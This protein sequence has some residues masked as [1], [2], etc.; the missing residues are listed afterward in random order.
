MTAA[1]CGGIRTPRPLCRPYVLRCTGRVRACARMIERAQQLGACACVVARVGG[2]VQSM[3]ADMERKARDEE[4]KARRR[5]ADSRR[6]MVYTAGRPNTPEPVAGR[7]HAEIQTETF[8][9]V[10]SDRPP[11]FE[12]GVQTDATIDRPPTPI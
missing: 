8:L 3:A 2:V 6:G 10:L 12:V 7:S 4:D 11:E 1:W 5:L 9:E